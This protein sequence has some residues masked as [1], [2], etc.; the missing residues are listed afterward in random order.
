MHI[1]YVLWYYSVTR[2]RRATNFVF[3]LAWYYIILLLYIMRAYTVGPNRSGTRVMYGGNIIIII[4]YTAGRSGAPSRRRRRR[5]RRRR[6]NQTQSDFRCRR[7]VHREY[8]I[9][10]NKS[11]YR[12]HDRP[13]TNGIAFATITVETLPC[14]IK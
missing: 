1:I 8:I 5:R 9:I 3:M 4:Y 13:P 6:A 7:R 14:S 12:W 10:L 2:R 11:L